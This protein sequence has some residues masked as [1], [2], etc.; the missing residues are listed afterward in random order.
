M[1]IEYNNSYVWVGSTSS[2]CEHIKVMDHKDKML[3]TFKIE[4]TGE[5]VLNTDP[6]RAE[7][8][9]S[10][11]N[12]DCGAG[13]IVYSTL[14]EGETY[15]IS[16]A[17][18]TDYLTDFGRIAMNYPMSVT[19]SGGEG[20]GVYKLTSIFKNNKPTYKNGDWFLWFDSSIL[21]WVISTPKMNRNGTHYLN[22]SPLVNHGPYL[23]NPENVVVDENC[24]VVAGFEG[25]DIESANGPYCVVGTINERSAYRHKDGEWYIFW[26][27]AVPDGSTTK[28]R[29]V[30]TNSPYNILEGT[31]WIA[32]GSGQ[33]P[34]T[35]TSP[36]SSSHFVNKS[37]EIEGA[38]ISGGLKTES[39]SEDSTLIVVENAEAVVTTE[40][41]I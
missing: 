10:F 29:W 27:P 35:F 30:L 36:P 40:E 19:L 31:K 16:Y 41:N 9:F 39:D 1:T 21:S 33:T 8:G 34:V 24:I 4:H 38:I 7:L 28:A 22:N 11:Q 3:I 25:A 37:G 14:T 2:L 32:N 5:R 13:A 26:H 20:A 17:V 18:E 6:E 23:S 12:I 15:D